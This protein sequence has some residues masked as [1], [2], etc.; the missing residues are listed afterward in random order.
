MSNI[1]HYAWMSL[2]KSVLKY[3]DESQP[4]GMATREALGIRTIVDMTH[5][6]IVNADRKLGYKFM[7][8]EA[9]WILSGDNRVSTIRPFSKDIAN[10]SDDGLLY[11]GAYGPKFRDQLHHILRALEIDSDSRQA[12]MTLWRPNPPQ[13]K[14]V[15]C[16]ISLSWMIRDEE[17]ICFANMRSSDVWL[18]VPYDWFNFS[19]MSAYILIMLRQRTGKSYG[20]GSLYFYAQSQHIYERDFENASKL[21][22]E[23]QDQLFPPPELDWTEFPNQDELVEHLWSLAKGEPVKYVFMSADQRRRR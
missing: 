6:V 1:A 3:G 8:A 17:L 9:A 23:H 4:R 15:P 16:T 18:G 20:L 2:V 11:F 21:V 13:T 12:V 14:D 10:Y 22:S 7:C 19:M 5:P